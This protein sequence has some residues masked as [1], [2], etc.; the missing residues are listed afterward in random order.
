M[1]K[2]GSKGAEIRMEQVGLNT[3]LGNLCKILEL[4]NFVV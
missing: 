3:V 2:V 1:L 4:C